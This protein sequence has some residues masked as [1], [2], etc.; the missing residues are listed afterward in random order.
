MEDRQTGECAGQPAADG[1]VSRAWRDPQ[2]PA[3]Q[4]QGPDDFVD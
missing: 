1:W 3:I 4:E 2:S